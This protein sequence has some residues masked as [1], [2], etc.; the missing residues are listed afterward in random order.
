MEL[1]QVAAP[2]YVANLQRF[3]AIIDRVPHVIQQTSVR[4]GGGGGGGGGGF[5]PKQ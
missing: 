5:R 1:D 2:P 3:N 4:G